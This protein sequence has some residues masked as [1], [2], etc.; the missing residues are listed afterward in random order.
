VPGRLVEQLEGRQRRIGQLV[1]QRRLLL[2]LRALGLP[3]L[4]GGRLDAQRRMLL[5]APPLDLDHGVARLAREAAELAVAAAFPRAQPPQIGVLQ[6]APDRLEDGQ[7]GHADEQAPADRRDGEQR[8]RR[9]GEPERRGE[10][11]GE[12]VADEA[13][14]RERQ[15]DRQAVQSQALERGARGD[16]EREPGRRGGEPAAVHPAVAPDHDVGAQSHPPVGREAEQVE[17]HIGKPG[18]ER[19]AGIARDGAGRAMRPA[20]VGAVE[21]GEDQQQVQRRRDQQQPPGLAQQASESCGKGRAGF[22]GYS[23][24]YSGSMIVSRTTMVEPRISM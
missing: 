13:A 12:G 20:R 5:L 7:P 19:T 8:E 3:D 21:G 1:E 6:R 4:G 15:L 9:A 24:A 17:Q 14:R 10:Q 16:Q 23:Q 2:L 22:A 18:A 11:A